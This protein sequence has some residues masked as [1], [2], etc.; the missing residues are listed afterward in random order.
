M[1]ELEKIGHQFSPIYDRD[2]LDGFETI[3]ANGRMDDV[4]DSHGDHRLF[5][6]LFLACLRAPL[7]T[8]VVGEETLVTSFPEFVDCFAELGAQVVEPQLQV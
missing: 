7:P 8:G 4:V 5:M 6:A 1:G 3:A 2:A